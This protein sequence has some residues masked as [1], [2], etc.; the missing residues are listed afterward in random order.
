MAQGAALGAYSADA[1]WYYLL[2]A[3]LPARPADLDAAAAIAVP[4]N[5]FMETTGDPAIPGVTGGA[6]TPPNIEWR[7][8]GAESVQF[9][10]DITPAPTPD[11][12]AFDLQ[13][14]ANFQNALHRAIATAAAGTYAT[15][16]CDVRTEDGDGTIG[17]A[18][19]NAEGTLFCMVVRHDDAP[20]TIPSGA[21][22]V[23][24]TTNFRVVKD[25]NEA[26]GRVIFHYGEP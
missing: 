3:D 24:A 12:L 4:A 13:W 2:S 14:Q 10:T 7:V 6:G 25:S 23:N 5:Q 8:H 9:R 19:G 1:R 16:I 26:D 17:V 15:L 22:I 20:V 11:D 18:A 21:S